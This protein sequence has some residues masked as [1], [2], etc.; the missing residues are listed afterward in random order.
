MSDFAKELKERL[1]EKGYKLT[2]Q[3]RAVLDILLEHEGEHLSTEEIYGY[4]KEK[5]PEIGLATVYRTLL[6]LD[7]LELIYKLDLDDGC[8]RYEMNKNQEDHRHHHLICTRC[9]NVAEVHEDLL[10]TLEQ[11]I[12]LKNDFLVTDHRLKLYGYCKTCRDEEK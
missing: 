11:E 2:T 5:C 9:G 6:L 12:L 8:S 4:V 3:R 7:R 1:K 10:D